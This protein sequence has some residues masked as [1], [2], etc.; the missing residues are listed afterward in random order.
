MR[1]ILLATFAALLASGKMASADPDVPV[2]VAFIGFAG[3]A[4]QDERG[5][6]SGPAIDLALEILDEADYQAE[7]RVLPA[8]RVWR[9]LAEG[10]IDLWLGP[11]LGDPALVPL[12][13]SSR[14]LGQI[15]L[16]L[17]GRAGRPLPDWPE[18]LQGQRV[19]VASSFQYPFQLL[20]QLEQQGIALQV[21]RVSSVSGM[22][23]MLLNDRGDLLLHYSG[24]IEPMLGHGMR[25]LPSRVVTRLP[26][27]LMV[28][29]RSP[30]AQR[31]HLDMDA[32]IERLAQRGVELDVTR[33]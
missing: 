28:S 9:G 23:Q 25:P 2:V 32:A 11:D 12:L 13:K 20:A 26:M 8:A 15:R 18:G 5:R 31:I 24:Q 6:I 10:S 17:Y 4:E 22:L 30:L 14:S 7:F 16:S 29:A 3:Y 21:I 19:L 1:W 33:R 27:H